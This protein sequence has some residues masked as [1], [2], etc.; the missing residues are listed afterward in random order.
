MNG[1][2]LGRC[3]DMFPGE[4]SSILVLDMSGDPGLSEAQARWSPGGGLVSCFKVTRCPSDVLE[5]CS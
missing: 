5:A 1:P 4:A 2:G 3:G